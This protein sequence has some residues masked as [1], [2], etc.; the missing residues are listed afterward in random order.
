MSNVS[1][2][3]LLLFVTIALLAG[4]TTPAPLPSATASVPPPTE[5]PPTATATATALPPSA[6]FTAT[7]TSSSRRSRPL[8][9]SDRSTTFLEKSS[10]VGLLQ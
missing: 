2:R 10:K 4:C 8:K 7:S 6:T 9:S 3:F 5:V 1:R